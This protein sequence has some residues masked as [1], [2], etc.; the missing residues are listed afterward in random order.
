MNTSNYCRNKPLYP[1]CF[2]LSTCPTHTQRLQCFTNR[3]CGEVVRAT[4]YRAGDNGSNPVSG[5]S[6][7]LKKK[8]MA[9]LLGSQVCRDS[10]TTCICVRINNTSSIGKLQRKLYDLTENNVESCK[11][12]HWNKQILLQPRIGQKDDLL[13]NVSIQTRALDK[14]SIKS[15]KTLIWCS[16]LMFWVIKRMISP[17]RFFWVPTIYGLVE[18]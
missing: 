10:I 17:R 13:R 4:I 12:Q 16:N 1:F 9:S 8:T 6:K 11:K 15:S 7:S 18:S 14:A 2:Y 3:L 5:I